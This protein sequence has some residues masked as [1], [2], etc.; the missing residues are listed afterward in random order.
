[1]D[2]RLF[3]YLAGVPALGAL[4][5]WLAW[6]LRLPS[7]L[8]LLS[9]GVALG[10]YIQPDALLAAAGSDESIGPK[11]LFPIVSLSVAIILFEGGLTLRLSELRESG[12]VV[13]RL[14]TFAALISWLLTAV[15]AR[16]VLGFDW[17]I[18]LLLGAILVVTG[19]T[20][21]AP[22]LR[23]IRP[24]RRVGSIVKWEGIVIDPIGA[25]LAVLVFEQT[26]PL[27]GDPSFFSMATTLIK[28]VVVGGA[29]GVA[30]TYC[31][32]GLIKR[33]MLPD[34]LHGLAFFTSV[35]GS[36]AL[37]NA[38]AHESGLITVTVF[39]VALANQRVISIRH[40]VEFKENLGVILLSCLFI[41]L[42]SR[43][44]PN[45]VF[46]LGL[47][48]LG[49]LLALVLVVRPV[50]VAAATWNTELSWRERIFLAFLAPR[51]IVAA[52]VSSVFALR[53]ATNATLAGGEIA[54]QAEKLVPITFLVIIGTVAIYG[55]LAS[56]V[57][58]LLK[59]S[60]QN[61][62]GLLIAGAESWV[63]D[64]GK[65]LQSEGVAVLLV[66]TNYSHVAAA[67]MDGLEA[68][69][70]SILSEHAKEEL[71][72]GGIGRMLA[73]TPNDE[74]NALAVH[75]FAHEFGRANVYQLA[76]SDAGSRHRESV[77]EHKRGRELFGDGAFYHVFQHRVKYGARLKR[78]NLTVEFTLS[79]FQNEYGDS[80]LIL[81]ALGSSGQLRIS[82]A[83][84]PVVP[85]A[86]EVVIALVDAEP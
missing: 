59:L 3:Y 80:A 56:P 86:G 36:Y 44:E 72:L 9:F 15:C 16:L 29:M 28:T 49:F 66:D 55:L 46:Q 73:M 45:D 24:T 26:L 7:I 20:V 42:G 39:G 32:V 53:V 22:L 2:D 83:S 68:E 23:H 65:M 67:R 47:P 8:L 58:R 62:Q 37:S 5:Q 18:A 52:A 75:E 1:M 11:I 48:G 17:S 70:A 25:I 41:V 79:D 33:F 77:A 40:V 43:L 64:F 4:A 81:A 57:A 71:D 19:P 30:T 54:S 51:G 84:H 34:F 50:S 31:L 78:T 76:P 63:R 10:S 38:L 85:E 13:F 74:V 12:R 6:R 27:H 60:D 69:C 35:L 21:V 14:V 82:T 61:P